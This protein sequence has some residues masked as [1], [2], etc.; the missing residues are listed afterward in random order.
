MIF[1]Q[2]WTVTTLP[3]QVTIMVSDL[4]YLSERD[5]RTMMTVLVSI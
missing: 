5:P 1:F 4:S 2:R 3:S